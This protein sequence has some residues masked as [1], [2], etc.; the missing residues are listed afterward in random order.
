MSS[1]EKMLRGW[2]TGQIAAIF[3]KV[4]GGDRTKLEAILKD[5]V[6]VDLIEREAK[7]FDRNGRRIPKDLE[8]AVCDP[9]RN[10]YLKQPRLKT[11]DDYADRLVRFQEAFR[12]GPVMSAADFEGQ[13]KKLIYEIKNSKSLG[14][15]INGVY[16]PIILR[17][18]G[19]K[20]FD[21]GRILE[22]VFL[23]ALEFSHKKQFPK[24]EFL[25]RRSGKLA[26]KISIADGGHEKL[27][28]IIKRENVVVIYFPN[29]LQ[30]FSD[31]AAREQMSDLP[32]SLILSGG[33]DI[34]TAMAMYPDILARD[35]YTPGYD[36]S[37]LSWQ[38]PGYSL[39]FKTSNDILGFYGGASLG[40]AHNDSSSGLLFLG[41]A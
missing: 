25:N 33:F 10:F 15:L 40:D 18:I 11:V 36:L 8:A 12:S 2:E 39:D 16:L 31:F 7:L 17:Q 1:F 28:E 19:A 6:V 29:P 23:P 3:Y 27:V 30:G 5:E 37:A 41:S 24:R 20:H 38:P 22:G 35:F 13:S 14:N 9:D 32:E 4:S 34:A 21:Y 26:G